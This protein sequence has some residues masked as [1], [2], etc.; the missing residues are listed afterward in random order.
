MRY[1]AV[2][3]LL[4]M[5]APLLRA[6]EEWT[7]LQLVPQGTP[8]P[9]LK[10]LLVPQLENMMPG[11]AALLYQRAHSPEWYYHRRMP[12]Y[13]K[14]PELLS[15][16]LK[17]LPLNELDWVVN[18]NALKEV[19]RAAR[20]EQCDWD[21]TRRVREEG[22][23]LLL[24]DVQGF[25][26]Y[27]N[28]L[29]I[30]ARIQMAQG[31]WEDAAYTLQTGIALG[32]H[33]AEAPTL[34]NALVG[35]AISTIM[36][37]QLDTWVQ[38]PGAPNLYWA[39]TDLPQPL[40]SLRTAMQGERLFLVSLIPN[41]KDLDKSIMSQ[42]QAD[43]MLESLEN[44]L[45]LLGDSSADSMSN[46]A[47]I[48]M[49]AVRSYPEAKRRLVRQGWKPG[50]VEK[51]PV[52]QVVMLYSIN[53]FRR[54]QDEI[55][56][57]ANVPYW[58]ALEG[59]RNADQEIKR[60]REQLIAVP[61]LL[62]LPAIEKVLFA[63]VRTDRRVCALRCLEA[64][65]DYAAQHGKLPEKLEDITEVPIPNDPATG[66]PFEYSLKGDTARLVARPP[67]KEEPHRCN[68]LFY[69]LTLAPPAKTQAAS[70]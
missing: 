2:L 64:V 43:A 28:L 37:G 60:S 47:G 21:M 20:R 59:L 7:K 40:V 57:W 11:N 41:M 65:R 63:T 62:L 48:A 23:G 35:I 6:E 14:I 52:V 10:Y 32:R 30:R 66:K 53:E 68:S 18:Y 33:L 27:A 13:D 44:T 19:D 61:L 34:I 9:A 58:R 50:D 22:I 36:L 45:R 70:R 51:M 4:L 69:E 67:G 55:Y 1:L 54:C 12:I 15:T 5:A 56:K 39:L 16:P 3:P 49:L 38:T 29:A 24:P 17:D 31:K 25:R 42:S 26:E 46:R 8:T